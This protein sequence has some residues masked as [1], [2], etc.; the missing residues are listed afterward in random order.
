MPFYESTIIVRQDLS[1]QD[2]TKLTDQFTSIIEQGG[3]KIVKNEYWG[4]K[5]FAYKI[6]KHRKGH[7][8]MLGID[9]PAPA[10]KEM[11]R[12]IRINED[13]VRSLTINV[14]ALEE[15]PS[16]MMQQT[17]SRDE[18]YVPET[19]PQAEASNESAN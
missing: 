16:V 10:V 13:I 2:V 7:F 11:E 6:D 15:G 9:A 18:G 3:G 4:L 5:S 8:A 17:R 12:N 19:E 1:R 14:E